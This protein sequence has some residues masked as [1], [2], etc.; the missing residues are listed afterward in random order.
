CTEVVRVGEDIQ[1]AIDRLD[2]IGGCVC[3]KMGVHKIARPLRIKQSNLTMHGEA[4]LTTVRLMEGGPLV[5]QIVKAEHV[6]IEGIR[7]ETEKGEAPEPM[8]QMD[9]V[10][11]G[12]IAECEL[13]ITGE[14]PNPIFQ[15]IGIAMRD[16][17]DYMIES[18]D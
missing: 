1:A 4:P 14:K 3:L 9:F 16:C 6:N 11:S 8:I 2:G 15:A 17:R 5:L 7:F 18:V 10:R 12:H 13:R